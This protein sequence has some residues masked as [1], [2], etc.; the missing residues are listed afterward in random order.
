MSNAGWTDP[1][2]TL[3]PD[4]DPTPAEQQAHFPAAPLT[5]PE[6]GKGPFK[7]VAGLGAHRKLKHD[8]DGRRTAEGSSVPPATEVAAQLEDVE[9]GLLVYLQMSGTALALRDPVCGGAL[10]QQ[11]PA[12]AK[13]L[14]QLAKENDRVRK[15]LLRSVG[16]S[17]WLGVGMAAWPFLMTVYAH[18]IAPQPAVQLEDLPTGEPLQQNMTQDE[19]RALLEQAMTPEPGG[20]RT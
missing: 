19:L 16:A 20:E 3:K 4:P 18:H 10:V 7:S 11:A 5:C 6:C 14:L 13:A 17:G 2:A 9:G 15:W 1:A 8:V 12:I